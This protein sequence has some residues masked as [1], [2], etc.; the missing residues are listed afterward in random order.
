MMHETV[1]L[2]AV[3]DGGYGEEEH[4]SYSSAALQGSFS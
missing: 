4:E 2:I 1:S 3:S